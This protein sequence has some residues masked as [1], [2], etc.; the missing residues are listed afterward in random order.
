MFHKCLRLGNTLLQRIIF[1]KPVNM[2]R[3]VLVLWFRWK[4][5]LFHIY[6]IFHEVRYDMKIFVYIRQCDCLH[7]RQRLVFVFFILSIMGSGKTDLTF[8]TPFKDITIFF[9]ITTKLNNI[10]SNKYVRIICTVVN[11]KL[12]ILPNRFL[13]C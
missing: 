7:L 6:Q 8:Y 4:Y 1:I 10:L 12:F 3:G 9:I 13:Q 11:T 2:F 5:L